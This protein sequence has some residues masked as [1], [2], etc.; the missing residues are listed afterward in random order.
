MTEWLLSQ[1]GSEETYTM[2][3]TILFP[4]EKRAGS[5]QVPC[6]GDNCDE[7]IDRPQRPAGIVMD[8]R[9]PAPYCMRCQIVRMKQ[10]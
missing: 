3:P 1:E 2:T 4:T 10:K 6:V 7:M 9:R 8:D 5:E